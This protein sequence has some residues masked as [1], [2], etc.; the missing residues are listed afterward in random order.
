L[1][2][3]SI[4]LQLLL[5]LLLLLDLRFSYSS[6]S[7]DGPKHVELART[8][9]GYVET[10][11]NRGAFIDELNRRVNNP[12]GSPYCQAFVSYILDS[13]GAKSPRINTGLAAKVKTKFSF[14]A[15]D[16]I[17]GRRKVANGMI[18]TW[19]KGRTIFGHSGI[20]SADWFGISGKTIQANT[21]SNIENREGD[22][23]F[24]K[25]ARIE[26]YNYF[27]IIRFTPVLY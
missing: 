27:R 23:I 12:L 20:V 4:L 5:L 25:N 19:Q 2:T 14:S 26:P 15:W 6:R 18:V 3:Q 8:Y 17:L 1:H 9:V 7:D 13:A 11:K 22:G 16:V 24:E 10:G 21:S